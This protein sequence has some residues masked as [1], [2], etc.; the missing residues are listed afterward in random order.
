MHVDPY[1]VSDNGGRGKRDSLVIVDASNYIK[2]PRSY[3]HQNLLIYY[4]C[5]VLVRS[6]NEFKR[7]YLNRAQ[8]KA[9]TF[10]MG[11]IRQIGIYV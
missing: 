8:I 11:G 6:R 10:T 2:G 4:R 9:Y 5:L 1:L 7:D 3:L